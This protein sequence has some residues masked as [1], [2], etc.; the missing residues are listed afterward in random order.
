MTALTMSE[1][2]LAPVIDLMKTI[3]RRIETQK[4]RR[5][6]RMEIAA[7]LDLDPSRL[8]D[9]GIEAGDVRNALSAPVPAGPALA[10]ARARSARRWLRDQ[11]IAR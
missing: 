4:A 6:E 3:G 9:M 5:A 8:D 11:K 7:L 1:M 2:I 10:L